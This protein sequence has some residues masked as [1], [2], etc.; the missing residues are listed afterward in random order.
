MRRALGQGDDLPKLTPAGLR[1]LTALVVAGREVLLRR[2]Y[3]GTRVDDIVSEAGVSHGAFYR[4]FRNK[5]DLA[6]L[7][8]VRSMRNMAVALAEIPSVDAEGPNGTSALR[9]WLRRYNA[10]HASEM[11][12]IQVW[13]D[14]GLDGAV[15]GSDSAAAFDWGRRRMVGVLAHRDWGD[16][17][18]DGMILMALVAAFGTSTRSSAA[19]DAAVH[20]IERG[21]LGR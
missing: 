21:V 16:A 7:I 5:E 2:G 20:I 17:E 1:T 18:T 15:V 14:A 6:R 3:H 12:M 9:R 19:V 11:A 13:A 8:T 10:V 4:Y